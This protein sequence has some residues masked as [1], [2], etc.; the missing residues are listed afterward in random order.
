[1]KLL[2]HYICV[3]MRP[4]FQYNMVQKGHTLASL[5]LI[6]QNI[7]ELGGAHET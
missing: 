6:S 1:M 4:R 2:F 3:W 7:G 5:T